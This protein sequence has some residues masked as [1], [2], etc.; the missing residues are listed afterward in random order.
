MRK[1]T[2]RRK[3]RKKK[4]KGGFNLDFTKN[5]YP[6]LRHQFFNMKG[7]ITKKIQNLRKQAEPAPAPASAPPSAPAPAPASAPPSAPVPAPPPVPAPAPGPARALGP[8]PSPKSTTLG[9]KKSKK[10]YKKTKKR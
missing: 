8:A 1:Y 2:R 3:N 4:M 10:K 6:N 9:G 7:R 5:I